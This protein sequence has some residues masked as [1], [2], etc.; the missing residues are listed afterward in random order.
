M[1]DQEEGECLVILDLMELMV[2]L[3]EQDP[4]GPLEVLVRKEILVHLERWGK[5]EPQDE[6]AVG[7]DLG[8]VNRGSR[9]RR[10]MK[11]LKGRRGSRAGPENLGGGEK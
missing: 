6:L 4:L 11:G 5:L 3:V 7:G 8:G 2:Y 10:E 1:G 9:E